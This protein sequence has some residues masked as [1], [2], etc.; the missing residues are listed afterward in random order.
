MAVKG[1]LLQREMVALGAIPPLV[2]L[3]KNGDEGA[4]ENAAG[5]IRMLVANPHNQARITSS[6]VFRKVFI[7]P[8]FNPGF[9]QHR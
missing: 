2:D 3:M 7:L 4:K 1:F 8:E 6:L 9:V 5:A